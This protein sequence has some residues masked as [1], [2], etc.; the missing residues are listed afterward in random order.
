MQALASFASACLQRDPDRRPSA[1]QLL[2]HSLITRHAQPH[3]YV[4]QQLLSGLAPLTSRL[5]ELHVR[6]Y[7]SRGVPAAGQQDGS[8]GGARAQQQHRQKTL[9]EAPVVV[10]EVT[11]VDSTAGARRRG[12]LRAASCGLLGKKREAGRPRLVVHQLAPAAGDDQTPGAA[13]LAAAPTAFAG[14]VAGCSTPQ[15]G[16]DLA[17]VTQGTA[18]AGT[19]RRQAPAPA[20]AAAHHQVQLPAAVYIPEE[21]R[22]L[23][24]SLSTLPAG[25]LSQQAAAA[26]ASARGQGLGSL[27]A[28]LRSI[29][30]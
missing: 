16:K 14:L 7:S 23:L 20:A 21:T 25:V 30:A 28:P 18:A 26:S 12:M 6:D 27:W 10:Q 24:K 17:A 29:S 9:L 19:A 13:A 15:A 8:R 11:V 5:L 4:R 1:A 22:M 3:G 2:H